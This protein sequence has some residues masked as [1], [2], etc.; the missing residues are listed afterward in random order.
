MPNWCENKLTLIGDYDAVS[1][2]REKHFTGNDFDFNTFFPYPEEFQREDD[3][4]SEKYKGKSQVF[5]E[6]GMN[7]RYE[8][9]GTKWNASETRT[10]FVGL[11]KESKA[12][13]EISFETAWNPPLPIVVYIAD[14]YSK[15]IPMVIFD[16]SIFELGV[17]GDLRFHEGE[18]TVDSVFQ[19]HIGYHRDKVN[20]LREQKVT[21]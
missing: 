4:A 10:E 16:Y 5:G 14:T 1:Q 18:I 21:V 8:N 17:T 11:K 12:H 3:D 15:T 2:F 9:W 20:L 7:W 13:L 19:E 6:H